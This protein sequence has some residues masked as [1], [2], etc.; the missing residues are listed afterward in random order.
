MIWTPINLVIQT[1]AGVLGAHMAAVVAR[2]HSFGF[3]GHTLAGA[4]AGGLSGYFLQTLAL[5]VVT[6]S[7]SL[8]EP[9]PA[10]IAMLQGLAGM[11]AGAC[12]MLIV[13]LIKHSIDHHKSQKN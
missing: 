6:G 5:T 8:N 12:L 1:F 2:E 4:V 13:G 9:R 11:A 10:E 7:G 3:F